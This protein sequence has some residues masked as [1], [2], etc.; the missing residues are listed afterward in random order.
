MTQR[1]SDAQTPQQQ[2]A[3]RAKWEKHPEVI[4]MTAQCRAQIVAEGLAFKAEGLT[5]AFAIVREWEANHGQLPASG[6]HA[7][8]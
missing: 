7:G 5:R 1:A 4:Q 6:I 2:I 3:L 8:G